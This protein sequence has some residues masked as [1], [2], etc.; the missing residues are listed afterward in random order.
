MNHLK[1]RAAAFLAVLVSVSMLLSG[2]YMVPVL[3]NLFDIEITQP[4]TVRPTETVKPIDPTKPT[5]EP[6]AYDEKEEEAFRDFTNGIF[7]SILEDA[8][9][10]SV[11]FYVA[12]PERFGIDTSEVKWSEMTWGEEADQAYREQLDS[13][14]AEL[15]AFDQKKLSSEGRFM[16]DVLEDYIT[17]EYDSL[18]YTFYYEP[19]SSSGLQSYLPVELAEYTLRNEAD[20]ETY[21]ELIE[22]LPDYYDSILAYEKAKS[23]AGFFMED[24]RLDEVLDQCNDMVEELQKDDSF[25]VSTFEKRLDELELSQDVCNDYLQKNRQAIADGMIPAY[26]NLARELESL[27]GTGRYTGN[28]CS[29]PNGK[30]YYEYL[31]ASATGSSRSVSEMRT[32]LEQKIEEGIRDI[33]RL[34]ANSPELYRYEDGD[35]YPSTDPVLCL[36]M[37]EEK[38]KEDFPPVSG[39]DYEVGYVDD[40]LRDYLSPAMYLLKPYGSSD[41]DNILI[42]CDKG[43]EPEDIFITLAH[44]GYPGHMLQTNYLI[45]SSRYPLRFLL[46]TNGYSEGYA[47]YVEHYAYSYLD[48]PEAVQEYYRLLSEITLYLYARADIG[49]EYDGWD[50]KKTGDYM[51]DYFDDPESIGEWMYGYICGDPGGYLD[52]AIGMIEIRTLHDLASDAGATDLWFHKQ[53]LGL[54]GAPFA[55]IREYMFK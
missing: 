40:S 42:N 23:E 1:H 9:T 2:C 25:M 19:L 41:R 54:S 47:E 46:E 50:A 5:E 32:L 20:V 35:I 38:I 13:W 31:V 14:M 26:E 29:L 43:D 22:L 48:V 3:E 34:A 24:D 6:A 18:G 21:L 44:E 30:A 7:A 4:A 45:Q 55:I 11:H 49:I 53:L 27:R 16:Y 8:G 37:L 15:K 51:A 33:Q 17:L 12:E 10:M 28:L 36:K 52:Y 39:I